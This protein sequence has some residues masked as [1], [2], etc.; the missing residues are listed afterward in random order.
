MRAERI[1]GNN[2]NISYCMTLTFLVCVCVC[3]CVRLC[4]HSYVCMC[5]CLCVCLERF[6]T[7][8]DPSILQFVYGIKHILVKQSRKKHSS[9]STSNFIPTLIYNESSEKKNTHYKPENF[10]RTKN[11]QTHIHT[12]FKR[13]IN[14]YK[15]WCNLILI[16]SSN[17]FHNRRKLSEIFRTHIYTYLVKMR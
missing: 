2:S 5:A 17:S 3:V 15:L 16:F 8:L 14:I 12:I 13:K 6:T 11:T 1:V 10:D 7:Y 4:L 9:L